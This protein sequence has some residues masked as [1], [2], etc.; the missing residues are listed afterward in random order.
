MPRMLKPCLGG[1][2]VGVIAIFVPEA[3]HVGYGTVQEL[4]TPEGVKSFSPWLLLILP[5]LRILTTSLTVGSGGS[6]GIFGP[7]MV[8]GG[9][10]GAAAWRLFGDVPG[11]PSEPG[12]IVIICMIATFGSIAHVPLA[13][14][15]MV[16]EMTGNLSLLAPAMVAV[17][18]ASLVVGD[19]SIYESQVATRLDSPAHRHRF[20]IPLLSTLTVRR[21]IQPAR[22]VEADAKVADVMSQSDGQ[23][24]LVLE[25]A[26]IVGGIRP[27]RLKAV[28]VDGDVRV[29]DCIERHETA[30]DAEMTLDEALDALVDSARSWL[31]VVDSGSGQPLGVLDARTL[32][33]SYREAAKFTNGRPSPFANTVDVLITPSSKANGEPLAAL[34]FPHGARVMNIVRKDHVVVPT[35]ETRLDTGDH[36]IV[37][38]ETPGLERQV[39][40][41]LG[42]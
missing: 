35:G 38:L 30:L 39:E 15:L 36:V 4:L 9:V 41:L 21:A 20:A 5:L 37:G 19:A 18:V 14:L 32:V 42:A 29:G 31:P 17:A 12:P 8:I 23:V 27:E 7:G 25:G 26:D 2:A 10:F 40:S 3:I 11:F 13:M 16:G 6:G 1:V 34:S 28:A 22:V 24:V 33:S